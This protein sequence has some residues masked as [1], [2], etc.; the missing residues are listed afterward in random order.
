MRD[1]ERL[2]AK[3]LD[4]INR[5]KNFHEGIF[6]KRIQ[7]IYIP[8]GSNNYNHLFSQNISKRLF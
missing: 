6:I 4:A 5:G 8:H 1:P 3:F 2:G 7:A